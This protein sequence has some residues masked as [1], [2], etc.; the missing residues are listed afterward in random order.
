MASALVV[1]KRRWV[2]AAALF[3]ALAALSGCVGA[4]PGTVPDSLASYDRTYDTALGAMAD[5]KMVFSLQDRRNGTIVGELNGDTIKATLQPLHDGTIQ[6]SFRPQGAPH[7]DAGLLKRVVDSYNTR[8][9][10][11]KLL[12]GGLL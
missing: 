9:S 7:A 11:A 5:Q 4:P 10:Q 3:L 1:T 6:V 8:M 12:P 2:G